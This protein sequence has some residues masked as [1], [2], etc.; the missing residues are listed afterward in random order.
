MAGLDASGFVPLTLAEVR[1]QIGAALRGVFGA[2]FDVD[3]P[4]SSGAEFVGILAD[5][6]TDLWQLGQALYDAVFPDGSTGA[7]Q[8]R[9]CALTGIFRKAATYSEVQLTLT[10]TPS[11]VVPTGTK[12][13]SPATGFQ[14]ATLAP[15]TL[16]GGVGSVA[17]RAV[18]SGPELFPA[19]TV[20]RI[21]TPVAGLTAST[22]PLDGYKVGSLLESDATLRLRREA[23]LRAMGGGSID[24]IRARLLEVPNVVEASVFEN[25][26]DAT[27]SNGILAHGFEA[28]VDGG[29]DV[30]VATSI[31]ATKPVGIPACG[32][33]T[34]VVNDSN[35]FGHTIGFSRPVELDIFIAAVVLFRGVP[36]TNLVS[37]IQV[38]L[39][40]YGRL[41]YHIGTPVRSVPLESVCLQSP[42]VV[43]VASLFIGLSSGPTSPNTIYPSN[44]QKAKLDTSRILITLVSA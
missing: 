35:G 11:T 7:S 3:T 42:T 24:A 22:N 1:S 21:D 15:C 6:E 29:L 30:D 17:A 43:D 20:T 25:V 39:E 18:L 36:P 32:T 9:V 8:D 12:M 19:L 13:S 23:S 10:G 16:V 34:L 5:R 44:H 40:E 26:T 2:S 14:V 37:Q 4:D 28:V 38:A 41:S 27:D 31:L 33:T